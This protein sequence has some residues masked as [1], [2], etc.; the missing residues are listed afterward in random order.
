MKI[1][2]PTMPLILIMLATP[3]TWC[4]DQSGGK[5]ALQQRAAELKQSVAANQAKLRKYQ[6]L[7]TTQVNIKG[8]QK[9]Q[10]LA[11]CRYGPDGKVLKTPVGDSSP[12]SKA[13]PRGLKGKLVQKKVEEMQDYMER[14]K[15]LISH[16]APPDPQM[17]Q[18]AMQAGKASLNISAGAAALTLSDYYKPGD[19]VTFTLDTAAKKLQ[20]YNVDTYLDDPQKDI[21]T[22]T[23]Q[24]AALPD[25]T[26]Y[27]QKTVL[28]AQAKQIQIT[29]TNSGH[30]LA[31][32]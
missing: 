31:S 27:L 32:E 3:A 15:S 17:I 5:A 21:V 11:Q 16:Y 23:N 9:K 26:N 10:E 29:T 19:K 28:N 30:S 4:Q 14:L 22:M 12:Q 7:Q 20:S 18:T 25:G 13:P 8:E 24:F 2:I 1:R 6:W